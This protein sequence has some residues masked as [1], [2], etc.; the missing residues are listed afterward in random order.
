MKKLLA[1]LLLTGSCL[2]GFSQ[3]KGKFEF[4]IN[5]GYNLATVTSGSKTNSSYRSGIAIGAFGDYF[6]ANDWSIKIKL[7][8]DQKGWDKGFIGDT[9]TG[10]SVV[11]NYR[12]DYLSIPVMASWHFGRTKNWYLHGGPYVGVLLNSNE[13]SNNEDLKK[14]TNSVDVGL[15]LGIG[16][17]IPIGKKVKILFELDGQSGLTNVFNNNIQSTDAKHSRTSFNTGLVFDL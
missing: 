8:Y 17:K 15:D 13:T 1:G 12:M 3:E 9:N 6:I 11:T 10:Q 5:A 4:G 16:V 14:Y 7:T 2:T